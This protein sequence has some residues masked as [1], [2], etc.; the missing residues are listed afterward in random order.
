[1]KYRLPVLAVVTAAVLGLAGCA[2]AGGAAADPTAALTAYLTALNDGDYDAA[3]E[4]VASPGDVR[5]EGVVALGEPGFAE[6]V[7]VGADLA[8]DATSGSVAYAI[9]ALEG[10]V[11][12]ARVDGAW[13]LQTP[14][15][16]APVR[17]DSASGNALRSDP[18]FLGAVVTLPDGTPLA[19]DLWVVV[20]GEAT[21][22]FPAEYSGGERFD[23]I[24]Y[25]YAV[26]YT[27]S[28]DAFGQVE[29]ES[30][31]SEELRAPVFSDA[32]SDEVIAALPRTVVYD[33]TVVAGDGVARDASYE[34]TVDTIAESN[35]NACEWSG[36][37]GIAKLVTVRCTPT[38]VTLTFTSEWPGLADRYAPGAI[39]AVAHPAG[40]R[41]TYT[42]NLSEA[43]LY[44]RLIDEGYPGEVGDP[45]PSALEYIGDPLRLSAP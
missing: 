31:P 15:F 1:M 24:S 26:T 38:Q 10:S 3:L 43:P 13:K 21:Y 25:E 34:I 40:T 17:G 32:Y 44:L 30:E 29:V 14:L 39:G 2:G 27:P 19:D 28:D 35:L 11:G 41:F 23:P 5:A 42:T 4:L 8:S 37:R 7:Q 16:L 9:G 20:D 18:E 12:F 6:P 36:G 33:S 45:R 22:A